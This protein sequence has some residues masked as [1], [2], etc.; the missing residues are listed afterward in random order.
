[1][2]V[3]KIGE[4]ELEFGHRG[5][6][7]DESFI[8]YDRQYDSLWVQAT[9]KCIRGKFKGQQLAT[10]PATHTTWRQWRSLHPD[11]LVLAKPISL[12]E[13]YRHDS[14]ASYYATRRTRFGLVVFA[15]DEQKL[16]PLEMLANS[17][18]VHDEIDGRP[19][20][21]VFHAPSETAVAFD[22]TFDAK[23]LRF[24]VAQVTDSDVLLRDADNDTVWSG[25][26][27]RRLSGDADV[28]PRIAQLR[29]TQFVVARWRQHFPNGAVFDG[30]ARTEP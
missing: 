19:V 18:V 2:Y 7:L 4:E 21:V 1:M 9:G 24:E 3:R 8:F 28:V 12:I 16:Y 22:P 17:P 14:Y 13:R 10:M 23:R 26:T 27:G 25:L 5:W 29:T 20:L 6:L 30:L 11:T 15:G